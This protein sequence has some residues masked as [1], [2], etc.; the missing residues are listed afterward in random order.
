VLLDAG[1]PIER[2]AWG[3][4]AAASLG[5]VDMARWLIGRGVELDR[6]YPRLGVLRQAAIAAAEEEGHAEMA[7]FLRG[8]LETGP[9]P[10]APPPSPDLRRPA[11]PR[12]SPAEREG[13][14]DEAVGLIRAAGNVAARWKAT[15][16]SASKRGLLIC[17][18]A[19]HGALEIV[20][21]LLDAGAQPDAADDGTAPALTRAAEEAHGDV[22]RLLLERG[23][24]PNGHDGK[25]WL[26]LVGAVMSGAPA[27]VKLLLDA[28]ANP[29]STPAGTR[30][31]GDYLRGPYATEIRALLEA[32]STPKGAGTT[33]R[34]HA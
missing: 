24:S 2:A 15:G 28:G 19:G 22:V 29:K 1:L 9:A 32:P 33:K 30:A 7:A 17:H 6:T 8:E 12:A 26:P 11:P 5:K 25:S 4:I 27:I 13:L 14:R 20:A 10:T 34:G 18:A 3:V 21:A 23:A 31:V 16:A